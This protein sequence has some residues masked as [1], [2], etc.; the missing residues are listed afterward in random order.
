MTQQQ[1]LLL[2]GLEAAGEKGA[3]KREFYEIYVAADSGYRLKKG[4]YQ[5][6]YVGLRFGRN[7]RILIAQGLMP[8]REKDGQEYR[9]FAANEKEFS[10]ENVVKKVVLVPIGNA[11]V[12]GSKAFAFDKA[13]YE[14]D[15]VERTAITQE[16]VLALIA[17][18]KPKSQAKTDNVSKPKSSKSKKTA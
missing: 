1:K 14:S 6:D 18:L 4:E 15:T 16:S 8:E 13:N 12:A 10:A 9:Y 3:T 17:S 2:A 11:R 5:S 7:A